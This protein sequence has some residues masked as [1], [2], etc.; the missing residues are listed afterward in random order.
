VAVALLVASVKRDMTSSSG[1]EAGSLKEGRGQ[2]GD[3]AAEGQR[4]TD[5]FWRHQMVL[6]PILGIL[7][8]LVLSLLSFDLVM[9]LD[10]HWYSTLFGGYFFVGSFYSALAA[11][12]LLTGICRKR[13]GLE[14]IIL[15]RH[16][17]DLGKLL[18]AFSMMTGYLFYT[19]FLVIWYGNI[20][21]EARYVI[22]RFRQGPWQP[23]AWTVL[24]VCFVLP[25]FALLGRKIK[26]KPRPLMVLSAVLLGGMWLERFLL[27]APSLGKGE[28]FPIGFMEMAVTSGFAGAMALTVWLFLN[29]IPVLPYSDPLFREEMKRITAEVKLSVLKDGVKGHTPVKEAGVEGRRGSGTA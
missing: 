21:E 15:P 14:R 22:E 13:L 17:H 1:G 10:P 11:L 29:R 16:F 6:S 23:L 27:V 18:F 26:M 20:P 3:K 28:A 2:G 25:F 19:Q 5:R 7:Y 9:S 8:A 12:A 4:V 24:G